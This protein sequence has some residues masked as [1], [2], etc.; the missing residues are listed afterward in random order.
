MFEQSARKELAKFLRA[1]RQRLTP[2][3]A[4]ITTSRAR[5]A[6]GLRR[7]EVAF[8]ADMSAKW[9]ARLEMGDEANPSPQTLLGI[10]RA[11]HLSKVDI[12]YIFELAGLSAPKEPI[13]L[14]PDVPECLTT[15]VASTSGAMAAVTDIFLTPLRWN[16]IADAVWKCWSFP[17]PLERNILVRTF[18]KDRQVFEVTGADF[19]RVTRACAGV[20]RRYYASGSPGPFANDIYERI[21][22]SPLFAE[23]SAEQIVAE[24]INDG[25]AIV[26]WH[27]EI[28][29]IVLLPLDLRIPNRNDLV[30][31]FW[32]PANGDTR[33]K[34]ERLQAMGRAWTPEAESK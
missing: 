28:G 7:E 20:F 8:L 3:A 4:G 16:S 2:E 9:Y 24:E 11:L 6:P 13:E 31:R 18:N 12:D 33:N 10:A 27:L 32:F 17:T 22:E 34:F 25:S 5:R 19:E 26:R 23:L 29:E 14:R 30:V 1:R 15:L 21:R